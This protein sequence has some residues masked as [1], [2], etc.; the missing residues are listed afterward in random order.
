MVGDLIS[1]KAC[2][3]RALMSAEEIVTLHTVKKAEKKL[4]AALN[5]KKKLFVR[6]S[7]S[8]RF[9]GK[10]SRVNQLITRISTSGALIDF[11]RVKFSHEIFSC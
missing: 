8:L 9:D 7:S 6:I 10:K 11:R 5:R 3:E 4:E 1:P 2:P